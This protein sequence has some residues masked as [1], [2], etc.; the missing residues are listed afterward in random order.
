MV[1]D[2]SGG[3]IVTWQDDGVSGSF[4]RALRIDSSGKP[5]TGWPTCG[6]RV[7]TATG[8]QQ[9]GSA[10]TDGHGGVIVFWTDY[11]TS[12][13]KVFAQRVNTNGSLLWDPS[14]VRICPADSAQGF[15][16]A[17]SDAAGGALVLWFDTR[18]APP[19]FPPHYYTNYDVFAQRID[20]AGN[21]SWDSAGVPVCADSGYRSLSF[22]CLASDGAGGIIVAFSNGMDGHIYAQHLDASGTRQWT[23]DGSLIPTSGG[24]TDLA[25]DGR[26]GIWILTSDGRTGP[27]YVWVQHLDSS[28]NLVSTPGGI[29]VCNATN[30]TAIGAFN[31]AAVDDSGGVIVTWS[32]TRNNVDRDIY[33][34]R[35]L[36]SGVVDPRWPVNGAP[37]CT[38][39]GV[40]INPAILSDGLGGAIITWYDARN[41]STGYDIYAQRVTARGAIAAGWIPNGVALCTASGD[42]VYPALDSDG[43]GGAII[44][45]DDYRSGTDV[46]I[47]A[48]RVSSDGKVGVVTGVPPPLS[49]NMLRLYGLWPNP[50]V[51]DLTVSFSLPVDE[52][53]R[54]EVFDLSGRR[55]SQV[56]MS[57]GAGSH[58]ATLGRASSLPIGVCFI[59]MTQGTHRLVC[60]G[61]I[62][63]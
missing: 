53:V 22:S 62:T 34:Q 43:A 44:D 42:Q 20:A 55:L 46:D 52:P 63:R 33:A 25:P 17:M 23:P 21:L 3:I 28:G 8:Y 10:V 58:V 56:I 24:D 16:H 19:P 38:A 31:S 45:W 13:P 30:E 15:G 50:A 18:R 26:G 29:L 6:V 9:A 27:F 39:P 2:G 60:R 48:Q 36:A 57:P 4:I 14:G 32:D 1:P 12:P 49:T 51:R 47:Y 37:V 40:Q 61:V 7:C 5:A 41:P 59:R 11:R 35:V 54:F